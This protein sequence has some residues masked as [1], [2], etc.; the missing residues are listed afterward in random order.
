[1]GHT[2]AIKVRRLFHPFVCPSIPPPEQGKDLGHLLSGSV[3]TCWQSSLPLWTPLSSALW[4][5]SHHAI[6]HSTLI[7]HYAHQGVLQ[8]KVSV[9]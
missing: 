9:R 2:L 7:R 8:V 6:Y 1:M 4:K 5:F 3:R